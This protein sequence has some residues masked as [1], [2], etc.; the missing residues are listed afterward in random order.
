MKI[1]VTSGGTGGHIY[2]AISLIKY[3]ENNGEEVVFVGN[4]NGMEKEIAKNEDIKFIGFNLFRGKGILNKIKFVISMIKS[5]FVSK[6]IFNHFKPDVV[7]GFGNYISFPLCLACHLKNVP[8]ILHEQNST[9]GKANVVLGYIA[10]KI[11]YS[12]PLIK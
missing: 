12:I 11:G 5:F 6:K 3:L 10:Q 8:I 9:M 7:I 1:I 4:E 2:P